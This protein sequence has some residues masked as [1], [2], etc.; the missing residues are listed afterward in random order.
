MET[1]GIKMLLQKFV[2]LRL[3]LSSSLGLE[4]LEIAKEGLPDA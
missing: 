2:R 4:L 1:A 3:G